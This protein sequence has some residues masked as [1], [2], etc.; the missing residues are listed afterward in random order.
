[1]KKETPLRAELSATL[2]RFKIHRYK[3]TIRKNTFIIFFLIYIKFEIRLN[4]QT[5]T[6]LFS[7]IS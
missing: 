7:F 1:M 5:N 3:V 2:I 4:I 6:I